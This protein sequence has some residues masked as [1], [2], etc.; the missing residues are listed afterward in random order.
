M[1][2]I[3]VLTFLTILLC[4]VA[5]AQMPKY[6]LNAADWHKGDTMSFSVEKIQIKNS[7]KNSV[8]YTMFMEVVDSTEDGYRIKMVYRDKMLDNNIFPDS[9]QEKMKEIL[10]ELL[11]IEQT[12]YYRTDIAGTFL[13]IENWQEILEQSVR[14]AEDILVKLGFEKEEMQKLILNMVKSM[15][16]KEQ[17]TSKLFPEIPLLHSYLGYYLSTKPTKFTTEFPTQFG[18]VEGKGVLTVT[19]YNSETGYCRLNSHTDINQKQLKKCIKQVF[20]LV[21]SLGSNNIPKKEFQA[22]QLEMTDDM[23]LE[24]LSAQ[25]IPLSVEYARIVTVKSLDAINIKEDR[26]IIQKNQ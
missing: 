5:H 3:L 2:K 9:L 19:D 18:T 22:L 16:G 1:K 13:E 20:Q 24:Y 26:Y 25:G 11:N 14:Q 12:V 17:V 8:H 7:I 6:I 15:Y 23:V 21:A 4:Y 10:S